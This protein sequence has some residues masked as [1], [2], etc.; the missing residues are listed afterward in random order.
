MYKE[1]LEQ[2]NTASTKEDLKNKIEVFAAEEVYNKIPDSMIT[3]YIHK[4]D[5][6]S[7]ERIIDEILRRHE[8]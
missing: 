2:L 1:F 8:L 6:K 7:G 3:K 5:G 4:F